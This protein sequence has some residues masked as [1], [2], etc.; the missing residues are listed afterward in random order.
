VVIMPLLGDL[1]TTRMIERI[2]AGHAEGG[3]Q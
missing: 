1:S 2:V 3:G